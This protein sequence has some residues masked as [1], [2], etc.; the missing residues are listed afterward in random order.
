MPNQRNYKQRRNNFYSLPF[1]MHSNDIFSSYA[2]YSMHSFAHHSYDPHH[3]FFAQPHMH[4]R[5][6]YDRHID[7][8][9]E[10]IFMIFCI[11]LIILIFLIILLMAK[12][13]MFIQ[14][15]LLGQEPLTCKD[16]S[17]LGYQSLLL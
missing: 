1:H 11:S 14:G 10:M 7:H 2:R 3:D 17:F 5:F 15:T 6:A 12:E 13:G 4:N 16:P 9:I 8:L